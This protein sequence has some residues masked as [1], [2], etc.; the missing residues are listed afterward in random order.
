MPMSPCYTCRMDIHPWQDRPAPPAAQDDA[1]RLN[2]ASATT[3]TSGA[4]GAS[5]VAVTALANDLTYTL[6]VGEARALFAERGRKVP[7]ERTLQDY[8][9]EQTISA[10]KIATSFGMEW[11]IN[12]AALEAFIELQ[13]ILSTAP[14]APRAAHSDATPLNSA[15]ATGAASGAGGA[16]HAGDTEPV[17]ERRTIGQVLIEN[18]RL[19]AEKDGLAAM[20]V[21]M[22]EDKTFFKQELSKRDDKSIKELASQMLQTLQ[23]IATKQ[24]P[25]L[26]AAQP[27]AGTVEATIIE[28]Q[29]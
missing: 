19:L 1:A 11:L 8:C 13:P 23:T 17:G 28:H 26:I 10:K 6:T 4:D 12:S 18:A 14:V 15:G 27:S 2:I 29:E 7:A 16:P 3:A 24:A 20:V 5:A 9:R 21:E 22:R 25:Q